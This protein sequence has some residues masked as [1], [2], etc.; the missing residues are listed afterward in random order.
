MVGERRMV[1]ILMSDVKGSSALSRDLDPE[2]WLDIM[3]GAFEMLIEP[4]AHYEGTVA[5]LEGD[6]I[7]AFFGAPIAHED[8]PERACRAGLEIIEGAK[9]YGV[10]LEGERGI[11]GFS[12]RVGIHTGLVVVGEVGT[13]LRM[14][15]TAMG[16]AP[17]L[18]AR[19]EGA[20]EPGTV[21]ISE[22]THKFIA[23]L[24]ETKPLGLIEVKG[25]QEPLPVFRVLA[26]REV[27]AKVRGIEGLESPLVGREAEFA[28]LRG[29]L[30]RLCAG[31]G[32]IVTVV[33]E[34]GI[35]KSR[36]VEELRKQGSVKLSEPSP[37][38]IGPRWT[39]GRCLSYGTSI[40]YLPWLD[41]LRTIMGTTAD[42]A[43]AA[44]AGA[45][46]E[47]VRS[48]CAGRFDDAYPYLA[49]MMS[50]PLEDDYEEVFA[51]LEGQE[52][53]ARTFVAME[54]AIACTAEQ[55]PLV[56]VLEDL[57]WSD[58][59]SLA[60]LEHL[61]PLIEQVP[62]LVVALFRPHKDHPSWGLRQAAAERHRDRHI[63]L[64]LEP[65]TSTDGQTLVDN[66]LR[67]GGLPEELIQHIL[68]RAEGNPFYVEEI[69][70]SLLD[71][72]IIVQDDETK[73][74]RV[75]REVEEIA[76]PDTLQG[77][78]LARID[79]LR[80]DTKRVL[81]MASVIGRTFLYRLLQ[82]IVEEER[83]LDAHLLSLQ[84]EE[85]I[86]ERARLPEMEYIFK[87]ELTREAA[88]NGLLRKQR[89]VFHRQVAEALERLFPKR[90]EEQL[91]LLAYH[92]ELAGDVQKAVG[93]LLRA[94]QRDVRQF[95]NQEGIAH[96]TRGLA[97]LE[98][99]PP[100]P[101]RAQ[102]E[103]A[104]QMGLG[105]PLIATKGYAAPEVGRAWGRARE[106]S[107]QMG[108]PPQLWPARRAIYQYYLVRADHQTALGI[109]QQMAD[110]GDS[111]GEAP[112]FPFPRGPLGISCFYLGHLEPARTHLEAMVACYDREKHH[113]L[114][115][116]YGQDLGVLY[117]SYLAWVLWFMGHA[118]QALERSH[119]A[120]TLAQA[121][122][123]PFT[124]AFAFSLAGWLHSSRREARETVEW[125][126]V[127][128]EVSRPRGFVFYEGCA[129]GL[130]GWALASQGAAEEGE[131]EIRRGLAAWQA[132][133]AE[134]HREH[135]LTWLVEANGKMGRTDQGLALLA[136]ALALVEKTDERYYE[137][138]IRRLQGEFLLML[139]H[140]AEAEVG[141][142]QAIE[143]ARQ[144][145]ARLLELRATM[146]L[147]RLWQKQGKPEA[148]RRQLAEIYD[149]FT[150]GFDT[151]DL[152]DA[153][154]LLGELA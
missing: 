103:F 92:W 116:V 45:L 106:L 21:L 17:N 123:H 24:F 145:T 57:H 19:L 126:E 146:S 64:L 20:A 3:G 153:K 58:A 95:A 105:A 71:E 32:G 29:A 4:I 9:A 62:L 25:W 93:Y 131:A 113:S 98:S 101:E 97:L 128:A 110:A 23:P 136:E 46:K 141:F 134:F 30:E 5:R 28:A 60:L 89:R 39:E 59:T 77:V 41:V 124:L 91:G 31:E 48:V 56:L 104:L 1:T 148:A 73:G 68:A 115:F 96:F 147:S 18:T 67:V 34:A 127:A 50:L 117:L 137:A 135:F 15:Y 43:S 87:H 81:Q 8:D 88:Y 108:D 100:A 14:E 102:L 22:E 49:Q 38:L 152:Q 149:W 40:A 90:V 44:A 138:E 10:R 120:V 36:L 80:E 142:H 27:S 140:P 7:M 42:K 107:Q 6:A 69:I 26:A 65:L 85:M 53:R 121:L 94:A 125:A 51:R 86:R 13:D 11:R 143:V 55:R 111:A 99:L 75:T 139:G 70:R 2:E 72:A 37:G 79:R 84:R 74:W 52:L 83:R 118:D 16:E 109:A 33:G 78:L 35:G 12:V 130:R 114:A 151:P 129:M 119:E 76:I 82:A 122:D 61:L 144:Q 54:T 47:F 154:E 112:L 150:E 63:D 66:L 133:G 132:T